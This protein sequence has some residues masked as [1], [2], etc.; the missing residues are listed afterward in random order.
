VA[1]G[2]LHT[3]REIRDNWYVRKARIAVRTGES[4]I[5]EVRYRLTGM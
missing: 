1:G 5:P 2:R 3:R 4:Y